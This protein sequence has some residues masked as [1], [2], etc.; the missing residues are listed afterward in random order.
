MPKYQIV[1]ETKHTLRPVI[2]DLAVPLGS[3]KFVPEGSEARIN[4]APIGRDDGQILDK[5]LSLY[6]V[7][8]PVSYRHL[9]RNWQEVQSPYPE[10]ARR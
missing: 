5:P 9:G 4:V 10:D 3:V 7:T 6:E 1:D 8:E 2:R